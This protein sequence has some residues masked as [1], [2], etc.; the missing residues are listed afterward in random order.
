MPRKNVASPTNKVFYLPS[1]DKSPAKIST[2]YEVLLQVKAK[3]EA[4]SYTEAD[5][6]LDHAI[7]CKALL[8][9][10]ELKNMQLKAL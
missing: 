1:I 5:L 3:A 2:I 7:Y 6:V 8:I 9:L 4:L 10:M